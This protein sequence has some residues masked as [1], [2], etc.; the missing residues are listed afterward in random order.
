MFPIVHG[1]RA[2]EGQCLAIPTY[3]SHHTKL[4]PQYGFKTSFESSWATLGNH[5]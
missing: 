2:L 4:R 1:H 5:S 3:F